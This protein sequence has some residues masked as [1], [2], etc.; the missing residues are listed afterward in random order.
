MNNNILIGHLG[1][2]GCHF[3]CS[4][5][6]MSDEVYFN[7]LTLRGKVEYFF[8]SLSTIS[9]I[10]GKPIWNDVFMFYSSSYQSEN[11]IHCRHAWIN[12][13]NHTYEQFETDSKTKQ[14]TYIS[15]LHVPIYYPLKDM[16]E[17]NISHPV[18][19]MFKS[20]YFICLVNTDLFVSLRSI[21]VKN[22][23][24]QKP[25]D[26]WDNGFAIIP[27]IK[28][29]NGPL[30]EV[31]EI[32][33]S[34][35]ISEFNSLPKDVQQNILSHHNNNLDGL[36]NRT[37]LYK[38]DNDLLKTMITHQWDCNWF[39]NEDDTIERLKFLYYEMNLGKVNEKIIRKMYK[40]WV[41]K[42]DYIK[43]WY[44]QDESEFTPSIELPCPRG[45]WTS[46]RW[47]GEV[48]ANV[49]IPLWLEKNYNN[50]K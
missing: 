14:E 46:E 38:T 37:K 44:I 35:T 31:D 11:Y 33:N 3:L 20:K 19:E 32:T 47:K 26:S 15:R 28:W 27:D 43:K 48:S 25:E 6:T 21:K 16:M 24:V 1:W 49:M 18:L 45:C 23:I 2:D 50:D 41:H 40:M 42:M 12:D 34:I 36:F 29:F 9:Q 39:L 7:N 13:F 8:K 30:T 22:K 4:C 10:G 5:L 17:K